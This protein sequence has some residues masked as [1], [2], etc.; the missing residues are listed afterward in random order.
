MSIEGV[1][2]SFAGPDKIFGLFVDYASRYYTEVEEKALT[3]GEKKR[4]FTDFPFGEQRYTKA[5]QDERVKD[6]GDHEL[7][8][9]DNQD[10]GSEEPS[11]F[12]SIY[13]R[14][15]FVP[16]S[17]VWVRLSTRLSDGKL[18]QED[19]ELPKLPAAA[20]VEYQC[21]EILL[22]DDQKQRLS[23]YWR[24]IYV[25]EPYHVDIVDRGMS[26]VEAHPD[27]SISG[28]PSPRPLI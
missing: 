25:H 18:V 20:P 27:V 5:R 14:E 7:T 28:K 26:A 19:F 2:V 10:Y 23:K 24:A 12:F 21:T 9:Y 13:P 1:S 15:V 11:R 22:Q 6:D 4:C 16:K 8:R 3:E 17:T